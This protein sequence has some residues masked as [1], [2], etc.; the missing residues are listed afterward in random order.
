ML[1][2][3]IYHKILKKNLFYQKNKNNPNITTTDADS[4]REKNKNIRSQILNLNNSNDR[5][6]K[7]TYSKGGKYNNI[8]TTYIIST[9]KSNSKNVIKVNKNP[10]LNNKS[11]IDYRKEK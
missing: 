1:I 7:H 9:K 3:F 4:S 11:K 8:Q 10:I 2:Q 6:L 5:M